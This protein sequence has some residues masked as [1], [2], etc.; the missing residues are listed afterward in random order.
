MD[1]QNIL[2]QAKQRGLSAIDSIKKTV[3]PTPKSGIQ[4]AY[5]TY[6]RIQPVVTRVRGISEAF[7]VPQ[8]KLPGVFK[9]PLTEKQRASVDYTKRAFEPIAQTVELYKKVAPLTTPALLVPKAAETFTRKQKELGR[10]PSVQELIAEIPTPTAAEVFAPF[11]VFN[12]A[13]TQPVFDTFKL[14]LIDTRKSLGLPTIDL[15]GGTGPLI[16]AAFTGKPV[17]GRQEVT[18]NEVFGV[19]KPT[20]RDNMTP[21]EMLDYNRQANQYQINRFL[22]FLPELLTP[23][24]EVAI[25]KG[26]E[27]VEQV[28][29][30]DPQAIEQ[31]IQRIKSIGEPLSKQAEEFIKNTF[32][33]VEDVK[34]YLA[35]Q[36]GGIK[37]VSQKER[38]LIKLAKTDEVA[39][40]ILEQKKIREITRKQPMGF[41]EKIA[42]YW[43]KYKRA[44]ETQQEEI[45]RVLKQVEKNYGDLKPSENPIYKLGALF[46]SSQLTEDYL[47]N[48]GFYNLVD[49]INSIGSGDEFGQLLNDRRLLRIASEEGTKLPDEATMQRLVSVLTPKYKDVLVR[50]D[51]FMKG[52]LRHIFDNGIITKEEYTRL[53]D[54]K[55]YAPFQ[56]VF[57]EAEQGLRPEIS[58]TTLGQTIDPKVVQQRKDIFNTIHENPIQSTLYYTYRAIDAINQNKFGRQFGDLIKQGKI[59]DAQM[60]RVAEDV[61][62][63]KA[64]IEDVEQLKK[65]RD[66]VRNVVKKKKIQVGVLEKELNQLARRGINLSLSKTSTE[67]IDPVV[68]D[69]LNQRIKVLTK[70]REKLSKELG[71][72]ELKDIELQNDK[73]YFGFESGLPRPKTQAVLDK[74]VV[75]KEQFLLK[76][77]FKTDMLVKEKAIKYLNKTYGLN[78]LSD[79]QLLTFFRNITDDE[80]EAFV[81]LAFDLTPRQYDS[82]I[83]KLNA[84]KS[85]EAQVLKEIDDAKNEAFNN[86]IVTALYKNEEQLIKKYVGVSDQLKNVLSEIDKAKANIY[87]NDLFNSLVRKSPEELEIINK[88]LTKKEK[89]IKAIVET[90]TNGQKKL[91]EVTGYIKQREE[92]IRNLME[93]PKQGKATISWFNNGVREIAEVSPELAKAFTVSLENGTAGKAMQMAETLAQAWKTTTVGL[94]PDSQLRQFIKDQGSM[95]FFTSPRAKLSVLNP[96]NWLEAAYGVT[97]SSTNLQNFLR[98]APV[99]GPKMERS[100]AIARKEYAKFKKMGGGQSSF[101]FF[102]RENVANFVEKG[103]KPSV[104]NPQTIERHVAKLEEANR[105]ELY[106]IQKAHYLRK[107]YSITDAELKALYDSNNLLP[108]YFEK[109]KYS[110]LLELASPF[111]NAKIKSGRALRRYIAEKPAEA[112]FSII[113]T[114]ALPVSAVTY[115]NLSDER[116]R[117]AYLDIPQWEKE[118]GLVIIP[119]NPQKDENG[120][121]NFNT[122]VQEETVA[123]LA[124]GFRRATELAMAEDPNKVQ[125]FFGDLLDTTHDIVMATTGQAVGIG[126]DPEKFFEN[127]RQENAAALTPLLRTPAELF[128]GYNLFTGQDIESLS[129]Q[130]KESWER[131]SESSSL[132]ARDLSKALF[133]A[134]VKNISPKEID[135]FLNQNFPGAITYTRFGLDQLRNMVGVPRE[136]EPKNIFEDVKNTLTGARK[137]GGEEQKKIFKEQ[138]QAD[139]EKAKKNTTVKELIKQSIEGE[140]PEASL[141]E[142]KALAPELTQSQFRQLENA[143]QR[144]AMEETLTPDQ[145]FIFGFTTEELDKLA[146]DYPDRAGDVEVVKQAKE[147]LSKQKNMSVSGFKFKAV[148]GQSKGAIKVKVTKP[149]K[150][151]PKKAKG[152]R[153]PKPPAPK[154]LRV[155]KAQRVKQPKLAKVKPL[156]KVSRF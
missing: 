72:L 86:R 64:L 36:V 11:D 111:N 28:R 79:K 58:Q 140:T 20:Y 93:K 19:T 116:R 146:Q 39:A 101:D 21:Q 134:G 144:E 60:L 155:K 51:N 9:L 57:N 139:Y 41:K 32:K 92:E 52:L 88:Q 152:I 59:E 70:D 77:L 108:N 90:I 29:N 135:F 124:Q 6:Q 106:R 10:L 95:L 100:M 83:K 25:P 153:M 127:I 107:G 133:D 26:V 104:L 131:Y 74:R 98:Q 13:I 102:K 66:A 37:G 147:T 143:V 53:K 56:R 24:L 138:Q 73:A 1:I 151:R 44:F 91:D 31:G 23:G 15:K 136:F 96:L 5:E 2:E 40:R 125:T 112:T 110:R 78:K 4:T 80:L 109:G 137:G 81:D 14:K 71:K 117:K 142:L 34:N 84:S 118:R 89:N 113:T 12:Q 132:L 130:N 69:R 105:F 47:K 115:W 150:Y 76:T 63:R 68:L 85:K 62:R 128:T 119:P 45:Y 145:K 121:W 17:D 61:L 122:I 46:K 54:L 103:Q 55:D 129:D 3:T 35:D 43:E 49:E 50:Y 94:N 7:N 42:D 126:R 30:I 18:L 156:K 67:T 154:K 87:Y 97:G 123:G 148:P 120:K 48:N 75:S 38:D 65:V 27:A 114:V 141:E 99:I 22:D 149:K 33:T 82:F 16:T 8:D